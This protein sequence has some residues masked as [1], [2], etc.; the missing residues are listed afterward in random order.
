MQELKERSDYIAQL[1]NKDL[2]H[3]VGKLSKRG[4][5]NGMVE[6][7]REK[8]KALRKERGLD[9]HGPHYKVKRQSLSD[10]SAYFGLS[11]E[12][13]HAL[14]KNHKSNLTITNPTH[15]DWA[16]LGQNKSTVLHPEV[17][18]GPYYV[19]GEMIR[20]TVKDNEK[21]VD[22][23]LDI[24]VIDMGSCSPLSGL[25]VEMWSCNATGTYSGVVDFMNGGSKSNLTNQA[26][27]GFQISDKDGA[28]GFE[29]I[30]P[31]HYT[32]RAHH[33]HVA[34]HLNPTLEKNGTISASQVLH[35]GQ[36]YF[37]QDLTSQIEKTYPYSTNK[38]RLTL[39]KD[40]AL[41]NQG[42][43]GGADPVV[44]YVLLGND[45]KDGIFAWINFG[46]DGKAVR[47]MRPATVC[48]E[49]G[50]T[51][52]TAE[53]TKSPEWFTTAISSAWEALKKGSAE[54][55]TTAAA[56]QE[57]AKSS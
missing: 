4:H 49:T 11:R 25:A 56:K 5:Y 16:L 28:V 17:T 18:E 52:S 46:V 13:S 8:L 42:S 29:T 22:L 31:G 34:T 27:R 57:T 14:S 44:E 33:I 9:E 26:L 41:L 55:A 10:L 53:R 24:Q 48:T 39:N 15:A 36:L 12:P 40:D 37:D 30:V 54:S 3:C 20:K 2:A 51:S 47:K 23:H 35:V 50:C 6:R 45:I 38:A 43:A 1:N 32:G 19:S 7:R 21:G